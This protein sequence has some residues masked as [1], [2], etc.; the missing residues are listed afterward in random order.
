MIKQGNKIL[1]TTF[2]A[3]TNTELKGIELDTLDEYK[4]LE[5]DG[6]VVADVN[7]FIKEEKIIIRDGI[8]YKFELPIAT[9]ETL[10]VVKPDGSSIIIDEEG[11]ISAVNSGSVDGDF[12][13]KSINIEYADYVLLVEEDNIDPDVTYYITNAPGSDSPVESSNVIV[14]T[15]SQYDA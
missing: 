2:K 5:A 7:Y 6:N 9:T 12:E 15:A 3:P 4:Q 10:G 1:A 14:C 8:E 13:Q 11:K